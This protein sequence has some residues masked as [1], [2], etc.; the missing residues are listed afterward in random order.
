MAAEAGAR[1]DD[2]VAVARVEAS[3]VVGTPDVVVGASWAHRDDSYFAG[4]FCFAEGSSDEG[5]ALFC[6][7][8]CDEDYVAVDGEGAEDFPAH[9]GCRECG[10]CEVRHRS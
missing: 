10:G 4:G 5:R 7:E 9:E 6:C 8:L 1:G 3:A 2:D